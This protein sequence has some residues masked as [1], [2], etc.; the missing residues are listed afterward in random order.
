MNII[1]YSGYLNLAL[2]SCFHVVSFYFFTRKPFVLG[3]A[4]YQHVNQSMIK[5]QVPTKFI[6]TYRFPLRIHIL[7]LSRSSFW[8]FFG[9]RK[10]PIT[11]IVIEF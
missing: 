7:Y 8:H 4:V 10:I 5:I 1:V 6:V 3:E 9:H 2:L 11:A